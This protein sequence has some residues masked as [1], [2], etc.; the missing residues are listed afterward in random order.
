MAVTYVVNASAGGNKKAP[1]TMSD[2]VGIQIPN[3]TSTGEIG[4]GNKATTLR[5][6]TFGSTNVQN[7]GI[8]N[9]LGG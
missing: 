8:S 5:S 2:P 7:Y 9:K 4:F 3:A 6:N 1:K